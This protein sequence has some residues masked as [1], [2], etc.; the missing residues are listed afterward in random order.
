MVHRALKRVARFGGYRAACNNASML[1]LLSPVVHTL[2]AAVILVGSAMAQQ[3]TGSQTS[4]A[5]AKP[6]TGM[7]SQQAAPASSASDAALPTQKDKLSYAI[8]MNIG[9]GLHKDAIDVDP[10]MI[11]RGLKDGMAGGT[12]LMTDE[13]AQGVITELRTQMM[14]KMAAEHQKEADA[15]KKEGEAFLAANKT[16][17]G[18]VVLPSGLQY[19]VEKQ[20]SGPKPAATDQV[21]CNYK[22]TLTNG[23][24]FDSSEKHGGPATFP[25]NG[26]IKG[27]TEALQLMPVG[28]KWQLYVPADLAYGERG[29]GEVIP[30][31]STLIF[32]VELVSIEKPQT[33]PASPSGAAAATPKER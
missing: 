32:D 17:P 15:N 22:G 29:A 10:N 30:P 9:K 27:W 4:S 19:K 26:V 31:N 23:T 12:T 11:L 16:K 14:A 21:K 5:P 8:G 2:A 18:V 24:E 1:K 33:P 13:Q 20:G 7:Q 6:A 25:V 28:S 3:S